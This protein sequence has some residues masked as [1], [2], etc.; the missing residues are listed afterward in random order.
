MN[1]LSTRLRTLPGVA[2]L[3]LLLALP[4]TPRS[5]GEQHD[6]M[7][8][9]LWMQRSAEYKACCLQVYNQASQ[10]LGKALGD[11]TWT[12]CLEQIDQVAFAKLPPAIIVDVDETV[13]D[14]GGFNARM[15]RDG[16]GFQPA[17]WTKWC[18]EQQ[19]TPVPG[20]LGFLTTARARGIRVVYLTNRKTGAE[21]TATRANLLRLGYPLVEDAGEDL[22]LTKG[23]VG[24]KSAR[25]RKVCERY[26]VIALVGDN[27]GDFT[28]PVKPRKNQGHGEA[29]EAA[30]TEKMRDAC[31][32][33][34]SDYW[35]T[36][37][38]MLPNPAYG[39][40]ESV[41]LG[42][43]KD[44]ASLL[45]TQRVPSKSVSPGKDGR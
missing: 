10:Q 23:E 14:N 16:G 20:S 9:V 43:S 2:S 32:A 22:V 31:V 15:I 26:R 17:A 33:E 24:D 25:R 41:L 45:R 28:V 29:V 21:E 3:V 19:A 13:L 40:W 39:S 44:K 5:V 34:R 8:A 30:T 37:W 11:R 12:A 27:F 6:Q 38:F 36:R 7:H 1:P 35:G 42:Q 4:G 18:E